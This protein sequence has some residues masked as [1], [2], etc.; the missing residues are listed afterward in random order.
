VRVDRRLLKKVSQKGFAAMKTAKKKY[1][2]RRQAES[3]DMGLHCR[4]YNCRK[5]SQLIT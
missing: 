1:C 5:A 3:D 2:G 4:P